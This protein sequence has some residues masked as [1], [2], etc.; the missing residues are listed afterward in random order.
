M[1]NHQRPESHLINRGGYD[2]CE[3]A[4]RSVKAIPA[5]SQVGWLSGAIP[6]QAQATLLRLK[7][8]TAGFTLAELLVS[9][10]VL[11]LLVFLATQ[12]INSAATVEIL[13]HKRMDADSEARQVF[14]RMAIDFAQMVKRT[15][16][17]YYVKLANQQRQQ[18]D[19]IAFYSAVPGYYPT[20]GAQS[21][22]SLVAYRVNSN[23]ASS[24]YNRMERLG[25]GLVWNGVS[26][27]DTPVVF[28]PLT[29]SSNWPSAVSMTTADSGY[30]VIGP[31]VFR[32]EYF[33]L[34]TNG[35]LSDAPC[36]AQNCT[37]NAWREVAAI[38]VDLAV[39]DPR[40]KLLL[41][42][43][44]IGTLNGTSGTTNFLSD[45][46]TDLNRPGQLLAQ[47]QNRLNRITTLPRGQAIGG[48]RLYERYFY[49]NQ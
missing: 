28:L 41:T 45:F 18:N 31:D 10:S 42:N 17:D 15:D 27:T 39:I 26:Q 38:V 14:D 11:V 22:V 2:V 19:Q 23:S 48:V 46:N 24:S 7:R 8:R 47:W 4:R 21:P 37:V 16:V 29:I 12:L 36:S 43:Q 20:S 3:S 35:A 33:Y 44:Q 40:S 34:R 25:K 9:V 6:G 5:L 1:C 32:F 49:L 13:G 30:E